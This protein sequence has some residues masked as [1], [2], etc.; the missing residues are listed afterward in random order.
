MI[1]FN[2]S[3]GNQTVSKEVYIECGIFLGATIRQAASHFNVCHGIELIPDTCRMA[4]RQIKGEVRSHP[5]YNKIQIHL[6]NS[7]EV[8]PKVID[9]TRSTTFLLDSHFT[10]ANKSTAETKA[11]TGTECPLLDELK[12]I[13]SYDWT[14]PHMI[15]VDDW[16]MFN[17]DF[18]IEDKKRKKYCRADWPQSEK[19][20]MILKDYEQFSCDG[21]QRAVFIIGM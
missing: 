15:I 4:N 9:P 17:A 3:F 7:V 20:K 10:A 1:D 16:R 6:G 14:V 21:N 5:E 18:W 11:L 12:I 19:I 8:L 2:S 13:T